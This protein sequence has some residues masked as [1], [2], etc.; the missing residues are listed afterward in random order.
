ML[1]NIP[2]PGFEDA[3]DGPTLGKFQARGF[4]SHRYISNNASIISLLVL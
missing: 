1:T 3:V 2:T 4:A